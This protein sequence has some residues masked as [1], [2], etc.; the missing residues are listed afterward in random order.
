MD[1]VVWFERDNGIISV[2]NLVDG[3]VGDDRR[4]KIWCHRTRRW[5]VNAPNWRTREQYDSLE[6]RGKLR[7]N[8]HGSLHFPARQ[9]RK[10]A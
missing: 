1:P 6:N 4:N 2:G 10:A 7:R 9:E 3:I 8:R 5:Y